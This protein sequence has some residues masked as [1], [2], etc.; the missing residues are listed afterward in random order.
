MQVTRHYFAASLHTN[1]TR[2][3]FRRNV[4]RDVWNWITCWIRW[5]GRVPDGG[6]QSWTGVQRWSNGDGSR[7]RRYGRKAYIGLRGGGGGDGAEALEVGKTATDG[8]GDDVVRVHGVRHGDGRRVDARRSAQAGQPG[9]WP[10]RVVSQ[11]IFHAAVQ[12]WIV[13]LPGRLCRHRWNADVQFE[14]RTRR[15]GTTTKTVPHHDLKCAKTLNQNCVT[16]RVIN[17]AYGWPCP[18]R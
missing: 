18:S 10:P 11:A 17:I 16:R 14:L 3:L 12:L 9:R 7:W 1:Q 15:K 13:L 6:R 4:C 5:R 2:Q 8:E